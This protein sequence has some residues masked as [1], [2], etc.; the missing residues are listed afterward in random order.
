MAEDIWE[1][2]DNFSAGIF[3]GDAVTDLPSNASLMLRNI[4]IKNGRYIGN[5]PGYEKFTLNKIIVNNVQKIITGFHQYSDGTTTTYIVTA[6]GKVYTYNATTATF[7]DTGQ[8]YTET[9][10]DK[11]VYNHFVKHYHYV[12]MYNGVDQPIYFDGTSWATLGNAPICSMMEHYSGAM[13]A[14]DASDKIALLFSDDYAS[15]TD[16]PA[17][18]FRDVTDS[19]EDAVVAFRKVNDYIGGLL[20]S[21]NNV[22]GLSGT[23]RSNYITLIKATNVG[24]VSHESFHVMN[25]MPIW[26]DEDGFYTLDENYTPVRFY[27]LDN[28]FSSFD[29]ARKATAWGVVYKGWPGVSKQYLCAVTMGSGHTNNNQMFAYDYK[30]SGWRY[31]TNVPSD[32]LTLGKDSNGRQILF[33]AGNDSYHV[34]KLYTGTSDDGEGINCAYISYPVSFK[35]ALQIK[36][37]D[38]AMK[39]VDRIE[40]WYRSKYGGNFDILVTS[41]FKG[42]TYPATGVFESVSLE[43]EGSVPAQYEMELAENESHYLKLKYANKV[44]F[45]ISPLEG[46]FFQVRINCNDANQDWEI[47]QIA[48]RGRVRGWA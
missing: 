29:Y 12:V 30:T 2:I 43:N 31:D 23:V 44:Q 13:F 16:W 1:I 15:F 39:V 35:Q 20:L 25:G 26:L 48:L 27:Q 14:N 47:Y 22:Y 4:V 21:E 40:I 33:G 45:D 6:G 3:D 34:Y 18:Y 42:D 36:H 28:M 5:R 11:T 9:S 17:S 32:I 46:R 24:C 8:T 41:D 7:T 38:K 19:R 37:S 10:A